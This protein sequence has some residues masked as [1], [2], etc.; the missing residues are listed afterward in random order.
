MGGR[1]SGVHIGGRKIKECP[2]EDKPDEMPATS[3]LQLN[4]GGP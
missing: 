1:D 2:P 3:S 4:M